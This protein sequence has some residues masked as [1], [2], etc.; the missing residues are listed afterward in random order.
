MNTDELLKSNELP[1]I[2][3]AGNLVFRALCDETKLAQILS[4]GIR[5]R[6]GEVKGGSYFPNAVS[7]LAFSNDGYIR[8]SELIWPILT[9]NALRDSHFTIDLNR[10]FRFGFVLDHKWIK[11]HASDFLAVG[12]FFKDEQRSLSYLVGPLKEIAL[13]DDFS[14]YDFNGGLL[15]PEAIKGIVIDEEAGLDSEAGLILNDILNRL[16]KN[17]GLNVPIGLYNKSGQ[18]E[19]VF[20]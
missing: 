1:D 7:L 9:A 17:S 11:E 16:G 10:F 14:G 6:G 12:A 2:R 19:D 18:L 8:T 4:G 15:P 20:G 13:P 3:K 5:P